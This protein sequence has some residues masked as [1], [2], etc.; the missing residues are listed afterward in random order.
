MRVV[1]RLGELDGGIAQAVDHFLLHAVARCLLD[2]LLVAA[3]H[4]AVALVQMQDVAVLVGEDLDFD[5]LRPADESLQKHCAVAERALGLGLRLIEQF[6]EVLGFADDAHAA[7]ATAEGRLDDQREA[8]LFRHGDR[9][10]AIADGFLRAFEDRHIELAG[11]AA[12]G[13]FV[14]HAVEDFRIRSDEDDASLRTGLGEL[15][16]LT[17]K[18]V[19]GVDG[20]H[21]FFLGQGDD[22]LDVEVGAERAFVLVQLVGFVR[23]EAMR[24]KAVFLRVDAHRA[25]AEFRGRAHDT[26]GDFRAVRDHEL[27][28]RPDGGLDGLA[29]G[30]RR[31]GFFR[32]GGWLKKSRAQSRGKGG[33]QGMRALFAGPKQVWPRTC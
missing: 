32:H 25:D 17:E 22:A 23:L 6:F 18:A 1:H 33:R 28:D 16:I 12:G 26:N 14:P 31:G 24:A 2:D 11:D 19:A 20:V 8:D 27:L 21:A 15:W 29:A 4:G 5:V 30:S 9:F 13:G 7:S 3:L 10:L